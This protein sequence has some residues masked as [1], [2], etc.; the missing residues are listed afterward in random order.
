MKFEDAVPD[1]NKPHMFWGMISNADKNM[2]WLNTAGQDNVSIPIQS[3]KTT[4]IDILDIQEPDD[5]S[6]C[7]AIAFGWC[8][9]SENGKPYL[10]INNNDPAYIFVKRVKK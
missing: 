10:K 9:E 4:L 7:Y 8:R 2:N 3:F 6:G 1:N 5:F